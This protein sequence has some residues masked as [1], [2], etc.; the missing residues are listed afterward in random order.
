MSSIDASAAGNSGMGKLRSSSA[1]SCS[2]RA[3]W[4][5]TDYFRVQQDVNFLPIDLIQEAS[6]QDFFG[7]QPPR[8]LPVS[9]EAKVISHLRVDTGFHQRTFQEHRLQ[10]RKHRGSVKSHG[11]CEPAFVRS[12][13]NL[14]S[15]SN[16]AS[17]RSSM[18]LPPKWTRC[19][20]PAIQWRGNTRR[21]VV[22]G[23][24]K[25]FAA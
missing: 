8:E 5:A 13:C 1:R 4:Y 2:W 7:E 11:N 16:S 17:H 20:V 9:D 23:A 10:A 6:Q 19:R 21:I 18:R 24:C 3:F 25:I 12:R 22:G 14:M 15:T